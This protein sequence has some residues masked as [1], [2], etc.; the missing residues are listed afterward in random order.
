MLDVRASRE[1]QAT[2]LA[3]R[4]AERSIRVGINRDARSSI[5]PIWRGAVN[6]R[7]STPLQRAVIAS[8]ARATAS[9]RGVSLLAATSGRP[10]SGG[11]VPTAN[12]WGAEQGSRIVRTIANRRGKTYPLWTGRQ[13]LERSPHGVVA[14]DAASETGTKLV[15][16]WVKTVV[17]DLRAIPSVDVVP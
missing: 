14:H 12:P 5:N 10:L 8:G 3:L 11:L 13:W 6:A 17:D 9:D 15:A 7:A 2:L 4:N 16:I 1:I